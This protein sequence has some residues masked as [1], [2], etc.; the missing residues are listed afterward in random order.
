MLDRLTL[1]AKTLQSMAEALGASRQ[2]VLEEAL[3]AGLSTRSA[4]SKHLAV[5]QRNSKEFLA[6]LYEFLKD[7]YAFLWIPMDC[8][9]I[10]E[11]SKAFLRTPTDY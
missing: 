4:G 6:I 10:H 1:D 11:S 5:I 9:R 2:A 7:S 8:I 3:H